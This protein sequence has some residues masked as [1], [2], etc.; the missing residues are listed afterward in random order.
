MQRTRYI[1]VVNQHFIQSFPKD[2]YIVGIIVQVTSKWCPPLYTITLCSAS[3]INPAAIVSNNIPSTILCTDMTSAHSNTTSTITFL[4]ASL[5]LGHSHKMY[6]LA[7][8]PPHFTMHILQYIYMH[9]TLLYY[10]AIRLYALN[11]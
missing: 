8:A 10:N 1:N 4:S 3:D 7:Y 11:E 9:P 2:L 5:K 6:T